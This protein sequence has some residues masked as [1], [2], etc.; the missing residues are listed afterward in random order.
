VI[1]LCRL[2][3]VVVAFA[4]LTSL[5]CPA[6]DHVIYVHVVDAKTGNAILRGNLEL[7][8]NKPREK[9]ERTLK[10]KIGP[11]GAAAF[12]LD[13]PPPAQVRIRLGKSMGYWYECSPSSYATNEILQ[14]GVSEQADIWPDTK[15]P[16][17]SDKFHAKPG[18]VYFFVGHMPFGEFVKTWFKGFK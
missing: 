4:S 3:V 2:G 18:E 6:S 12:H 11:D 14:H 10:E 5:R 16:N 13:D 9:H 8:W 7:R 15:F 17:V 1:R